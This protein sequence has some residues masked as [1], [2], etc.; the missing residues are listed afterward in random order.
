MR[1]KGVDL[2]KHSEN[3]TT[4]KKTIASNVHASSSSEKLARSVSINDLPEAEKQKIAKLAEKVLELNNQVLHLS[5]HIEKERVQHAEEIKSIHATIEG[6][7]SII[8]DRLK[9]KDGA[10]TKL[11]NKE[12]MITAMLAL[13]QAKLKNMAD[14]CRL[15]GDNEEYNKKKVAQLQA[16]VDHFHIITQNQKKL[17]ESFDETKQQMEERVKSIESRHAKRVKTLEDMISEETDRRL[18]AEKLS[19]QQGSENIMLK[20]EVQ[21]LQYQLQ[22]MRALHASSLDQEVLI[23]HLRRAAAAVAQQPV[24]ASRPTVVGPTPVAI[25]TMPTAIAVS[26]SKPETKQEEEANPFKKYGPYD[27]YSL[28]FNNSQ[29]DESGVQSPVGK[30]M[31]FSPLPTPAATKV[32]FASE[33]SPS[34]HIISQ[35]EDLLRRSRNVQMLS[36][37]TEAVHAAAATATTPVPPP[38]MAFPAAV[39]GS[40]ATHHAAPPSSLPPLKSMDAEPMFPAPPRVLPSQAAPVARSSSAAV[41]FRP[42]SVQ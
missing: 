7:I 22:Q 34:R 39:S 24:E 23:P 11:E 13:Y 3:T 25:S 19:L 37:A 12:Q 4:P 2:R 6:Q 18:R 42:A 20:A 17:I 27:E 26:S 36:S 5:R 29:G 31:A 16:D 10:I 33:A 9:L 35:A 32:P 14:I 15:A 21:Q 28:L 1:A 41:Q 38:S 30:A 40:T 8:E